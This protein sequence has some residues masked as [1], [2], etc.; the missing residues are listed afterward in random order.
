MESFGGFCGG[1]FV[2]EFFLWFLFKRIGCLDEFLWLVVLFYRLCLFKDWEIIKCGFGSEM[3][4]I[5]D[6]MEIIIYNRLVVSWEVY[7]KEWG[8]LLWDLYSEVEFM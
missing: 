8:Y 4:M 2:D 3:M 5:Y 6:L 7:E 1:I